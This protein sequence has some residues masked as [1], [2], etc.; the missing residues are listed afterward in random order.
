MREIKFYSRNDFASGYVLQKIEDF[1][2]EHKGE[3]E[4]ENINDIIEIYNIK[5]YFDHKVYLLK[6]T[7][8][9]IKKYESQVGEYFKQ[10]ARFFNSINEENLVVFF[11]ELDV[12]YREDFWTLFEKFKV[13]EKIT[14]VVFKQLMH[15]KNFWLYQVLKYK[16]L[17]QHFGGVI[18]EYMLNDH[19]AAELLLDAFEMEHTVEKGKFIFPKELTNPDKETIILNY[20]NSESPNLNYLRLIVNIQSN[21]DKIMLSP[22]T[23]LNAKK[24]V[25][26]EEKE[27]FP[28]ESGMLM[29]TS[30]GF[31]KSQEEAVIASLDGMSIKAIYSTKWLEENKDYE[32]LLNNFI[33]LFEFVD[34]Q[35][36]CNFVNKPN[37]MGVMER[38]M[39]SRSRNAYLT[40][41]AFNQM[42][43]LSLL[44]T[45]GYY[46]ELLS[47]GIR[48]ESVIEWFFKEYLSNEFQASNFDINMPSAH[49][50]LLEK[51]TNIMPAV[52]SVL[53]Q[54]S[55]FV[56]EG[57]VDFELLEIRSEHLIYSNIPS[58]VNKKYVYGVGEEFNQAT[59]ARLKS[60]HGEPRIG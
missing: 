56:E 46:N 50:T 3:K 7:F 37:Q 55:L 53:K 12:E 15:E 29:E 2:M 13:Y 22:R 40:G 6:W 49:S 10:V 23:L 34:S 36:R 58:L 48:L 14:D 54:F 9:E 21:K 26:K 30:V 33:Y 38:I 59:A 44:Q 17:V 32:T 1:L 35:M 28:E 24:R 4:L 52:E 57:I 60:R 19:S 8:D 11:N 41:M 47:L 5:Q 43:M 27:L 25:E 45:H 31:S 39:Y 20:I 51:C 42:N 16:S 18:K